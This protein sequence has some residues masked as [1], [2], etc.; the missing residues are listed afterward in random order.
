ME[1]PVSHRILIKAE[2]DVLT[3]RIEARFGSYGHSYVLCV[4]QVV[5]GNIVVVVCYIYI[6]RYNE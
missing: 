5:V 2:W 4:L 6:S 3:F 1:I